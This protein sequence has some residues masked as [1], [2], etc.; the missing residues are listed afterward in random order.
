MCAPAAGASAEVSFGTYVLAV[1]LGHAATVY[2]L[3]KGA[4]EVLPLL[5]ARASRGVIRGG[6]AEKLP[7]EMWDLFMDTVR[8]QK[9]ADFETGMHLLTLSK[10]CDECRAKVPSNKILR[11]PD[12]PAVRGG[13][14]CEPC[15][16]LAEATKA[17]YDTV[18]REAADETLRDRAADADV[19]LQDVAPFLAKY[20][21][22]TDWYRWPRAWCPD[23]NHSAEEEAEDY[24][25]RFNV[26]QKTLVSVKPD[27]A[28]NAILVGTSLETYDERVEN[29][30]DFPVTE[31]VVAAL[32]DPRW[33]ACY[34]RFFEDWPL[35]EGKTLLPALH[36]GVWKPRLRLTC[37]T[38]ISR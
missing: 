15:Q 1:E 3:Y 29:I 25:W 19:P 37:E 28:L 6:N 14:K 33:N 18:R 34:K 35:S 27:Q 17:V 16:V 12:H 4:L 10:M 36:S 31:Q 7:L 11:W 32:S 20:G 8:Q 13:G 21:L 23:D 24:G 26:A 38:S 5:R 9:H 2:E 22:K 30:V